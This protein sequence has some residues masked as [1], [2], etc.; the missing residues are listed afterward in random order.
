MNYVDLRGTMV[1]VN[2]FLNIMLRRE[3]EAY[4]QSTVPA[5]PP[6]TQH[7]ADKGKP[8][9][10]KIRAAMMWCGS[11]RA[12]G[13]SRIRA[14]DVKG[15][16]QDMEQEEADEEG[17][18]NTGDTW[19]L[20]G[21]LMQHIWET[22]NI[23]QQMMLTI[24][25]LIPKGNSGDFRGIGLLEVVWNAVENA[26]D[27]RLSK[28]PLHDCLHEFW[29]KR[30]CGTGIMEAKLVQQLAFAEQ[31]PPFGIFIDLSFGYTI[32]KPNH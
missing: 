31:C 29:K 32:R 23:P 15:R 2:T 24:V 30:G 10:T 3:Y 14:E 4:R 12:G 13:V 19:R 27:F 16:L 17:C 8:S 5:G 26:L 7:H 11:E 25:V 1:P 6:P 21:R 20:V 9:N 18:D 28:T 22:G